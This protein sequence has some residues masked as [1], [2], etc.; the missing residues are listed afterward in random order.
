MFREEENLHRDVMI[1]N[2]KRR[3]EGVILNPWN[4]T[5]MLDKYLIKVILGKNI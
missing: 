1:V 5:I 4:R 3:I 2:T